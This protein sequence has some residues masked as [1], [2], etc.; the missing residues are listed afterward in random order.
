MNMNGKDENQII[1]LKN[2]I[3]FLAVGFGSGL[4]P[5]A[6]GTCGTVAGIAVY[7]IFCWL[8]ISYYLIVLAVLT[9]LGFWF[10]SVTEKKLKGQDPPSIVWDEIVGYMITMIAVPINWRWIIL[11]FIFFR[12]FDIW[13]PWPV[14]WADNKIHGGFGIML[15]DI[16][17][18]IY[19]LVLLQF[20]ILICG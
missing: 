11:G 13:K 3:H 10:C 20:I 12:I 4:S 16:F 19:S 6:P 8:P 15:D 9:L 17:A 7:L 2:P 5:I 14:S 18:G 1:S